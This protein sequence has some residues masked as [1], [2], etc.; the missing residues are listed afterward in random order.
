MKR[1]SRPAGKQPKKKKTKTGARRGDASRPGVE[2]CEFRKTLALQPRYAASVKAGVLARLAENVQH[3]DHG[4][5]GVLMAFSE[6]ALLQPHGKLLGESPFVY[7][8][9]RCKASVFKPRA[10]LVLAG[11]VNKV[12]SSHVGILVYDLFNA[13][14]A[15]AELVHQSYGYH[16]DSNSWV[17]A[18]DEGKAVAV[19]DRVA[20]VVRRVSEAHGFISIEGGSLDCKGGEQ[21]QQQE[22]KQQEE[23]RGGTD[24]EDA[25]GQSEKERKRARKAKKKAKKKAKSP[26]S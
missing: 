5:Q 10:G 14:V 11:R 12:S 1:T 22:E 7:V 2:A 9:V 23:P 6:V 21:Q 15:A 17:H 19:G 16:E 4:V 3:Y 24:A 26:K 25:P 8:T 20:F 13:S 18:A